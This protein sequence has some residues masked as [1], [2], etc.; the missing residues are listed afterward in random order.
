LTQVLRG[1]DAVGTRFDLPRLPSTKQEAEAILA[2]VPEDR[3]MAALGFSATK[4]AAMNPDLKRYRIVHF[5]TH[6]ILNDDHPD[7]SSLVLSLVDEKGSPQ[8]GFLRLR[9][10]YNLQLSAE[11]VVLSACDTALGKEV[12]GEGLMSMVRGFMYSGTPRVLASLWKVDDEATAELMKEFYK[13]LLHSGMTPAA[14]LRQAQ[15]TQ[16]QKKTRQAPYYWAG[17]QLQ[18]EWN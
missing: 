6:T 18:G 8:S 1:S 16:M 11:L 15:I 10:M 12:K 3:R 17:F 13:N 5:A 14:S 4:A 2:M 9:D 7:L